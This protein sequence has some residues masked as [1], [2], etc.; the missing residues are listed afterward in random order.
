MATFIK[1]SE[2]SRHLGRMRRL[3]RERK[4]ALREALRTELHVEHE[5]L[6]GRGS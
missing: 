1:H 2:F 3:Y 6:G 4:H 5:I